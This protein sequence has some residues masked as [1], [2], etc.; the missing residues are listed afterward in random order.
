LGLF[1]ETTLKS[2]FDNQ[3]HLR[4]GSQHI[5]EE[6]HTPGL[7]Y[8]KFTNYIV[9]KISQVYKLHRVKDITSSQ[10]TSG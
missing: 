4:A 2:C 9:L 10:T 6:S 3:A 5:R 8:H 1:V 7:R